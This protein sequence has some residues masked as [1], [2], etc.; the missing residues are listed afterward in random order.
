MEGEEA[1][2]GLAAPPAAKPA[3]KTA[4]KDSKRARPRRQL[5]PETA[6]R[7][8]AGIPAVKRA[9]LDD[10]ADSILA[11]ADELGIAAPEVVVAPP[12]ERPPAPR[13]TRIAAR[14]RLALGSA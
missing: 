2:S 10:V 13:W 4:A 11:M 14:L 5:T 7:V 12:A 1:A 9:G 3:P 6:A 8:V